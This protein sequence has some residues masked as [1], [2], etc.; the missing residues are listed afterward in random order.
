[1]SHGRHIYIFSLPKATGEQH[2]KEQPL[3]EVKTPE[4]A[5][6]C[7]QVFTVEM[8]EICSYKQA[9]WFQVEGWNIVQNRLS[10]H[11]RACSMW[12]QAL[13]QN[14]TIQT[15]TQYCAPHSLY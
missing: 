3:Q 5:N 4:W 9:L 14:M 15:V 13:P 12:Q 1:M 6:Y 7:P 8:A 2:S 10:D 11:I